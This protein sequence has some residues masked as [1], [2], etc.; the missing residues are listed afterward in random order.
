MSRCCTNELSIREDLKNPHFLN[1]ISCHTLI[2]N[3]SDL[4]KHFL[5]YKV[6]CRWLENLFYAYDLPTEVR[7][8][9]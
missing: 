2:L 3:M 7:I 9:L 5:A 4:E 6:I 1:S 8:L